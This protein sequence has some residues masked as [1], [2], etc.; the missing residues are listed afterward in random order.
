MT[1]KSQ[2]AKLSK[3]DQLLDIVDKELL[4]KILNA[5]TKATD[6]TANIVDIQGR[7]TV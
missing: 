4:I 5:F 6:L 3:R 1:D 7:Q 2:Q